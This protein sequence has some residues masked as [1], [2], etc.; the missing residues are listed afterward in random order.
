MTKKLMIWLGVAVGVLLLFVIIGKKAGWISNDNAEKVSTEKVS[1]RDI[2]EKVSA[3]GKIYPVTEV[4]IS[5]DVSGEIIDL[6]IEEGDSVIQGQL[7]AKI[8][9]D[10]YVAQVDRSVAAVN[11][12]KANYLNAQSQLTQIVVQ[13]EKSEK[14]YNRNKDLFDKKVISQSE[15][16]I[17]DAAYKSARASKEGTQQAVDAAK[18]M[19]NSAEA[20][21]KEANDQLYKTSIYAPMSG[22][23]SALNVEKGERV[24]GTSQFAGT[25]IMRIA[26][27]YAM[28]ARVDV[29]ENDV[30]KVSV[31]DTCEIEVDAY[32]D[33]TF[34]GV[35]YQ[36]ANSASSSSTLV[37]TESV[38]NF[39]VKILLDQ[40]SFVDMIDVQKKK[41]PFLPGMTA[42]VNILTNHV[43]GINT[44]PIQSVTTREDS[45]D[46][47][48]SQKKKAAKDK[49]K[50]IVFVY[51]N[52]E[53]KKVLV[54][55]GIQ[56]DEYIEIKSG[57]KGDE[58]IITA[59]YSA[60]SRRLKDK[61]KVTKV[62]KKELYK[63]KNGS[64][65]SASDN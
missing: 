24:V 12:A 39:T 46:K 64:D 49:L 40:S 65:K 17:Y 21:L 18:F 43:Y 11:N 62:D 61:M 1:K 30:L 22:I 57:L 36:V 37:S 26:N 32:P 20:S 4:K 52:G 53:A 59:P 56:D 34:K 3:S 55:T 7:L 58:E 5:P 31:G 19:V 6:P 50:E 27:L 38:T 42:S 35:V 60:I 13:F 16:D 47:N 2:V 10:I 54:T 44:V 15:F 41:F 51:E 23:V 63:D 14:D 33:K 45:T 28:E 9:P 29:S 8:K 48:E 25:E